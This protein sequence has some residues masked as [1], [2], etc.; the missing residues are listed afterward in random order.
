[1]QRAEP[2]VPGDGQ[3][4]VQ[5]RPAGEASCAVEVAW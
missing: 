4:A 1:M 5:A 2:A 3:D